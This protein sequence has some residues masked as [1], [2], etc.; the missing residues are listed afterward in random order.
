M[1]GRAAYTTTGE[2]PNS[3][4]V[5]ITRS[6]ISPRLAIRMVRSDLRLSAFI[7]G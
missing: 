3:R 2:I 4:H 6:A 7:G 5:R 1:Q